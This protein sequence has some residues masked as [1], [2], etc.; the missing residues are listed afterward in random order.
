MG[1]DKMSI[2]ADIVFFNGKIY[3]MDEKNTVAEALAA[4]DGKLV[5]VGKTADAMRFVSEKTRKVD[6]KGRAVIP[7]MTD[8]HC[9]ILRAGLSELRAPIFMPRS[10]K[11]LLEGVRER[12]G[13]LAP[14]R[15]IYL[16]NIYPTRLE[17]HRFPTL[18]ELDAAAPD[19]P[20]FADGAFAGQANSCALKILGISDDS[21]IR[22]SSGKPTGL[23]LDPGYQ[24]RRFEPVAEYTDEER[25]L[26][27]EKM[28][29]QYN[30]YGIT[31]AVEGMTSEDVVETVNRLYGKGKLNIRLSYTCLV[32]SDKEA[33][34]AVKRL[35]DTVKTPEQW[36]KLSFLK[37]MVDGGILTGTSFM[38]DPYEDRE[39]VFGIN[40]PGY[41]GLVRLNSDEIA[42]VARV[43]ARE[44]L[45]MTAHAIGDAAVDLMLEAYQKVDRDHHVRDRRFSIIHCDFTEKA[46]LEKIRDMGI[47]IFF[48]PAWHFKDAVVLGKVLNKRTMDSFMTYRDYV[49][50]GI[51]AAGGSDHM[52]MHD[53]MLSQNPYNPFMALYN[54][55]TRKTEDGAVVGA[56]QRITREQALR[57]YT[58]AGAYATFD[59]DKR[60]MLREGMYADFAV[61]TRDYF[62]CEEEEIPGIESELTVVNGRVVYGD[63]R[64]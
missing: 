54:M 1:E 11:E 2:Q 4:K 60:G 58:V 52:I 22:D 31:A 59:E 47:Q 24:I 14:G 41:R 64:F 35:R 25:C 45:Q 21:I 42:A 61:L 20:V 6:L 46:T 8:T 38:R 53:S 18:A 23:I 12:A 19:N 34:Q 37:V 26:A 33:A 17:E 5:Y 36:A 63:G 49:E 28:S 55:V 50:M 27:L 13:R 56:E 39:G 15:W 9:H 7:G 62:Q 32:K 57:M 44:N 10:V 43:A 29:A 48:Q 30:R 3:T 16:R 51:S 40:I